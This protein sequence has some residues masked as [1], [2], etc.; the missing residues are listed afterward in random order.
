MHISF[1]N[2]TFAWTEADDGPV[3]DLV[4]EQSVKADELGFSSIIF[5]EKHFSGYM[6][7]SADPLMSA[8]YL[9]PQIKQAYLGFA[10]LAPAYFH[11]ANVV[12]RLNLLD[13][14]AKGRLLL[15]VGSGFEIEA[16]VGYGVSQK[17]ISEHGF[18]DFLEVADRLWAKRVDDPPVEIDTTY[19][20]GT[21]LE[22]VVPRQF[23]EPHPRLIGVAVRDQ[24]IT[25]A[26][27]NGWPVFCPVIDGMDGFRKR[28][29]LYRSELA[30]AGHPTE[31][32]ADCLE[33]TALNVNAV[34][35]AE[36]D[37][38]AEKLMR[39]SWASHIEAMDRLERRTRV[40]AREIDGVGG[41]F[42]PFAKDFEES[43]RNRCLFGSPDTVAAE[44]ERWSELGIGNVLMSFNVGT[45]GQ[46]RREYQERSIDLFA[47]EVLPR[48]RDIPVADLSVALS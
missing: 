27:K 42:R 9:A 23:T 48:V 13:H 8:A 10:I 1:V 2:N 32:V 3:I 39:D 16:M 17:E 22:R 28:M 4:A 46:E 47:A 45:Y 18:A 44:L 25:R 34:T 5:P 11:P 33:W 29:Q 7:P 37:E 43:L 12:E 21:I 15:G 20:H 14:Y 6:P 31:V 26:A 30:A 40:R 38:L 41:D 19:H 24:S 35:V 36:T